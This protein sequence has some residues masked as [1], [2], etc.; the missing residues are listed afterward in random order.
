MKKIKLYYEVMGEKMPSTEHF[1]HGF[2]KTILYKTQIEFVQFD[3][4]N[5]FF[6]IHTKDEIVKLIYNM[7]FP[8]ELLFD[9]RIPKTYIKI[10]NI[11]FN[12]SRLFRN[13][14]AINKFLSQFHKFESD[15]Y[16]KNKDFDFRKELYDRI[17]QV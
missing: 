10:Q 6:F 7:M 9:D 3:K 4:E 13:Y 2:I 5:Y 12:K 17:K 15:I 14:Y 11:L 16:K 8:F 1:E